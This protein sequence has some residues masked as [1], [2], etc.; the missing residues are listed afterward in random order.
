MELFTST[1]KKSGNSRM[2][3]AIGRDYPSNFRQKWY[4]DLMPPPHIGEA[5]E[6][7]DTDEE[8]IRIYLNFVRSTGIT[9][10]EAIKY[11][12][13]GSILLTSAKPGAR[14][15]RH[16]LAEWIERNTGVTV[17]EIPDKTSPMDDLLV[18]D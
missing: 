9:A 2:A 10:S 12:A 17:R 18:F 6:A 16:I 15:Y 13:D 8:F 14:C 11:M 1:F 5:M 4:F 3:I 7:S